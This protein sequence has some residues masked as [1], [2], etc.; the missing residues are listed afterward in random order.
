M[1][2]VFGV[3]GILG[4]FI[5]SALLQKNV[6]FTVIFYPILYIGVYLLIYSLGF[7]FSW[8]IG[9]TML[10]GLLHSAGLIVSQTWLAGE[11]QETPEFA[12]SLFVSFSNLGI[13]VGTAIAGWFITHFGT[14]N[15]VWVG[16]L[17][18]GLAFFSILSKIFIVS[19]ARYQ[20]PN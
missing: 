18:A 19:G 9:L 4:N 6:D 2:M 20:S 14:H 8:M 7:S 13:T 17:F 11:A 16:I 10:W 12:N 1:L 15:L 5:F 3:F